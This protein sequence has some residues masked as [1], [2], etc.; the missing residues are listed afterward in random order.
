MTQHLT[1]F[2]DAAGKMYLNNYFILLLIIRCLPF[3]AKSNADK[4]RTITSRIVTGHYNFVEYDYFKITN[5]FYLFKID[6]N[7][8]F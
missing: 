5:T 6:L 2:L 3:L 7:F 1:R 4:P 8:R